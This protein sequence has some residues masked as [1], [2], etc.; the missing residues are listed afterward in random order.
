MK[1]IPEPELMEDEAQ[2]RAYAQADFGEPHDHFIELFRKHFPGWQARGRVLDLGCGPADITLRFARAFPACRLLGVDGAQ[3]MLDYGRQAVAAAGLE[4]R[5]TLVR[6]RL[7][8]AVLPDQDYDAVI[9]NSLLHHLAEP[10]VLWESIRRYA[11][12]GAPVFVMDLMRPDSRATAR[13]LQQRY[14][15][16]EPPVLQQDFYHSL[17]AAYT[18]EE[19]EAQLTMAQLP[20]EVRV[21]SDRHLV[22]SGI[23][24]CG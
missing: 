8:E 11:G 23:M 12:T 4:S 21:V 2:A 14:A 16:D 20:F 18:P 19:V 13:D 17:L 24:P 9:S 1:R 10:M 7:P 3:A 15:A 5:V 6:A 22:V